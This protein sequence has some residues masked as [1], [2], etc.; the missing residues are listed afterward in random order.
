M[1]LNDISVDGW[2]NGLSSLL[3]VTIAVITGL[4]ILYKAQQSRTKSRTHYAMGVVIIIMG[5]QWLVAGVGFILL[6]LLNFEFPDLWYFLILSSDLALSAPLLGYVIFDFF[7]SDLIRKGG[8]A[9][10]AVMAFL[11]LFIEFLVIFGFIPLGD[12]FTVDRTRYQ[13]GVIQ[14][15]YSGPLRYV[16]IAIILSLFFFSLLLLYTAV[17]IPKTDAKGKFRAMSLGVGFFMFFL[18]AIVDG[19]L[20][21]GGIP[22]FLI[23]TMIATS[24]LVLLVGVLSPERMIRLLLP[25]ET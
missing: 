8:R 17:N 20:E 24:F 23:R 25:E 9:Y 16:L 22:L 4:L 3:I 7:E 1:S 11:V 13:E 5:F 18:F 14:S 15:T 6:I 12:A 10:L 21:L 19:L 2:G